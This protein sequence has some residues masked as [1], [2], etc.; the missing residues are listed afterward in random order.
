[1]TPRLSLI[2]A[3][4]TEGRVYFSL[5]QANTDQNVMLVFLR[6]LI[7]TLDEERPNWRE[8]TIILLDGARYHTGE[9]IREFLHKLQLP[10]IWSA[11]YS[12]A[13]APIELIFGGLKLGEHNPDRLPTGK[14]VSLSLSILI[15]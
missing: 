10:V 15:S 6:H 9:D 7:L 12:Y 14:K 2:A 11:P 8:D 4:D 3:L 5:T 13:T 1:M